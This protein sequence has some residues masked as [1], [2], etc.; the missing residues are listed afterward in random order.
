MAGLYFTLIRKHLSSSSSTLLRHA[1]E[2]W[3]RRRW[4]YG[5]IAPQTINLTNYKVTIHFSAF[6]CIIRCTGNFFSEKFNNYYFE[7]CTVKT[8]FRIFIYWFR[9]ARSV[10]LAD[11][12]SARKFLEAAQA[13]NNPT[14]FYSVFKFFEQRNQ[15]LRGTTAFS[16][17]A[18]CQSFVEHMKN[19][20]SDQNKVSVWLLQNS[21]FF[22]LIIIT[23]I[24]LIAFFI[25]GNKWSDQQPL[26][27]CQMYFDKTFLNI[28]IYTL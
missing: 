8:N 23:F 3:K 18:L 28:T 1:Q 9:F 22:F 10:G 21:F 20:F 2:T 5:N 11:Q 16:E 19:L 13:T 15:R 26:T 24:L 27:E 25:L 14:V 17:S 7:S 12:I 6:V 4:N